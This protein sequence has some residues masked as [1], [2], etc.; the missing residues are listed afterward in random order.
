M[1][2][3]KT[4]G[5]LAG[6]PGLL[7]DN[8]AKR[9]A[10]FVSSKHLEGFESTYDPR[11]CAAQRAG[12]FAGTRKLWWIAMGSSLKLQHIKRQK[13]VDHSRVRVAQWWIAAA[14]AAAWCRGR[15]V[16]NGRLGAPTGSILQYCCSKPT[17]GLVSR[18]GLVAYGF[19]LIKLAFL[20][21]PCMIMLG[22]IHYCAMIL[23]ILPVFAVEKKITPKHWMVN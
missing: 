22:I 17:Y 15:S 20:A 18:Y 1:A 5:A 19:H 12:C 13:I 2:A 4:G 8:I 11:H 16:R 3:N 9:T 23:K 10:K 6:I 21:A 14:V 7:K